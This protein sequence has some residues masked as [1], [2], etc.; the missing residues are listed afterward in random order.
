MPPGPAGLRQCGAQILGPV[1]RGPT[2][3]TPER[4]ER[5]A[6]ARPM[7]PRRMRQL[8]P[9][10]PSPPE[11]AQQAAIRELDHMDL[12]SLRATWRARYGEAPELR[13]PELLRLMSA[14]RVQAAAHGG[15]DDI[16][17]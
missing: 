6:S 3:K 9:L 16:A 1:R 7:S 12:E 5:T 17:R 15:L 10:A 8:T 11:T 14:W 13:S 4:M 2:M